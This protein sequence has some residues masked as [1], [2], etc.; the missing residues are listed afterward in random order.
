MRN[1]IL[2]L[3]LALLPALAAGSRVVV[4]P[5]F[6]EVAYPVEVRGGVYVFSPSERL[7]AE[8]VEDLVWLVGPET[9]KRVWQKK[10]LWIY[11]DDGPATLHYLTRGLSGR[12]RYTLDLDAGRLVAW[13]KVKNRLDEV[14]SADELY[15]VS[16]SVPLEGERPPAPLGRAVA[17]MGSPADSGFVGAAGG[18]FRYRLAGPVELAPEVTELVLFEDAVAPRLVWRYK[19]GFVRSDRLS[20]K[21]GY[22]FE[23]ERVPLAAGVVDLFKAG[24]FIG[25]VPVADRYLG[26]EVFLFLGPAE[27][28][29]SE[30][31]VTP[32]KESAEEKRYRVW[33]RVKNLGD[34]RARVE[35]E[36][37][38]A[39]DAVEL[40]L[41][42]GERIPKGYRLTFELPPGGEYAYSYEVVLR[43]KS[44]R[45]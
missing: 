43:F 29:R 44:R 3:W 13:L 34:E 19:G 40:E 20:L 17:K 9:K 42:A 24:A 28:A 39:A 41:P 27:R 11:A 12:V 22:A 1:L 8:L 45:R 35:I 21:R 15:F 32:L 18:V 25:R 2:G 37:V 5:E 7:A 14:V 4:Y 26:E 31:R 36:E 30:R 33:T 6:A 10:S 23:V 38:F 16:G